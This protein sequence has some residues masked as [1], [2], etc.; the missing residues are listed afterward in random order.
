LIYNS[1]LTYLNQREEDAEF[2]KRADS[3]FIRRM[4]TGVRN[5]ID[6]DAEINA[7]T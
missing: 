7:E 5:V 2:A 1:F 3:G 4:T 6:P